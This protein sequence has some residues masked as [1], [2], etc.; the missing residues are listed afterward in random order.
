MRGSP[1]VAERCLVATCAHLS[2][3]LIRD[4]NFTMWLGVLSKVLP[5]TKNCSPIL[6]PLRVSAE[7]VVCAEVG[8]S[9]DN[10]MARLR[11]ETARYYLAAAAG[12]YKA[13][14]DSAQA[15]VG[16]R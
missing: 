3:A 9:L 12:R 11:V 10:A 1:I 15:E 13:W 8:L 14:Q 6:V 2:L 4:E 16:A 7:D 5:D